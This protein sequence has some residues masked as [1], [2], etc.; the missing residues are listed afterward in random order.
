MRLFKVFL[1]VLALAAL[2]FVGQYF[3]NFQAKNGNL[4]E[5]NLALRLENESLKTQLFW[6]GKKEPVWLGGW[7]YRP[8]IVQSSYP[9]NNQRLIS[10]NL[11][12]DDGI[13]PAMP[14]AVFPGI[15]LGRITEVFPHYSWVQTIFD[16]DF[17][18]S[19]RLGWGSADGL[20]EGGNQPAISLIPKNQP[21]AKGDIIFASG[22]EFPYGMKIGNLGIITESQEDFFKKSP[23]ELAYNLNE[24]QKVYVVFNYL[25]K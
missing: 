25:P 9:F 3:L 18:A 16:P 23:A 24:V 12:S 21:A 13:K 5:E 15:L 20:L 14:V 6:Q 8:A 17:K 2:V 4:A 11:G 1:S 10:I 19:V 22:Q 7:E